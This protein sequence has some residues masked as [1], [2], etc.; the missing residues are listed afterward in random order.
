MTRRARKAARSSTRL[1]RTAVQCSARGCGLPGPYQ[2]GSRRW[3]CAL[4]AGVILLAR[5]VSEALAAPPSTRTW[6]SGGT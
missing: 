3:C 6:S 5:A 2:V 1:A 4:H